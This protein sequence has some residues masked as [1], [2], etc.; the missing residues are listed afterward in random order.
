MEVRDVALESEVGQELSESVGVVDSLGWLGPGP[1]SCEADCLVASSAKSSTAARWPLFF[2]GIFKP[3]GKG[4]L[5]TRFGLA[6]GRKSNWQAL[7]GPVGSMR[8]VRCRAPA[9]R[10]LFWA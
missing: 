6:H 7:A 8:S 1:C 10:V 3:N 2:V 4:V 9:G 5:A